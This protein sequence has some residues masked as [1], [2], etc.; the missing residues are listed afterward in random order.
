MACSY[1]TWCGIEAASL[2]KIDD[3]PPSCHILLPSKHLKGVKFVFDKRTLEADGPPP[4]PPA[5]VQ[6]PVA[7]PAPLP[8][9]APLLERVER[10]NA[11]AERARQHTD[12]IR[13]SAT[14]QHGALQ[15]LAAA[16]GSLREASKHGA[17]ANDRWRAVV[18]AVADE[19]EAPDGL[20]AEASSPEGSHAL[21]MAAE[22]IRGA[23]QAR[24]Q[25]VLALATQQQQ[26]ATGD[27]AHFDALEE[28]EA[29]LTQ[30]HERAVSSHAALLSH[31]HVRL[32]R[33]AQLQRH[34]ATT[35]EAPVHLYQHCALPTG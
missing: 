1:V 24:Q 25:A 34:H 6:L 31:C 12:A 5:A 11:L 16:L 26:V 29:Q 13:L 18:R 27:I 9:S 20:P 17:E 2:E 28:G 4:S 21:A 32:Q 14:Q 30:L 35:P 22:E 19:R 15:A 23:Q 7:L 8:E 33:V 3:I 10:A